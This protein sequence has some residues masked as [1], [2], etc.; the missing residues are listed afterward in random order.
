MTE[1]QWGQFIEIEQIN[2]KNKY[3]NYDVSCNENILNENIVY[4]TVSSCIFDI[5]KNVNIIFYK[6]C[7][8]FIFNCIIN[9][10][11]YKNI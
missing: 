1:T 4:K 8:Y 7:L 5:F 11:S 2:D 10:I 9:I 6:Q 3:I